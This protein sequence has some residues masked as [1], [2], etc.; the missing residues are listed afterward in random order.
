MPAV[1]TPTPRPTPTASPTPTPSP[2]PPPATPTPIPTPDTGAIPDFSAGEI[3]TALIDGLRVRQ[4][5]G[6]AGLVA[7]GLLP[8]TAEMEVVMGPLIVDDLGWYLV[9]DADADDPTFEEGWVAAGYEPDAFLSAT[10]RAA[11]DAPYVA[12]L[13]GVGDAEEGPIEIADD[14]HAVR[15]IARDPEGVRCSFAVSLLPPA[16]DP[17]A[18]IRATVG[19][20]IDRGT[21]QPHTFAALGV[22]GTAFV[23]V[24]SDCAWAMVILRV[25]PDASAAPSASAD[26]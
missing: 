9:R 11:T 20:G 17:V 21:L 5:P 10:G 16:G 7:T 23:G 4:R 22:R 24:A 12:S 14:D 2:T 25:P 15:W 18:T 3:V 6:T 19:S 13:A 8:R 1:S 26:P